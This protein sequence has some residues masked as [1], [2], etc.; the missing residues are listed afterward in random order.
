MRDQVRKVKSAIKEV[1]KK[2]TIQEI[3]AF[4]LSAKNKAT[5]WSIEIEMLWLSYIGKASQ[6]EEAKNSLSRT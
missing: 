2:K 5:V 6:N 4:Y 1:E 3:D